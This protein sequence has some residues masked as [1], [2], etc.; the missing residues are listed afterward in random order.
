MTVKITTTST[1]I[2]GSMIGVISIRPLYS[3]GAGV[4]G[5]DDP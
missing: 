1:K 3:A 4:S 5:S 2:S